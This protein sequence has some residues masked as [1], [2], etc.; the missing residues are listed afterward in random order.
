MKTDNFIKPF[1]KFVLERDTNMYKSRHPGHRDG[2]SVANLIEEV[3]KQFDLVMNTF[4]EA[5]RSGDPLRYNM[6]VNQG[7][8]GFNKARHRCTVVRTALRS[9]DRNGVEKIEESVKREL[10]GFSTIA[11]NKLKEKKQKEMT[12]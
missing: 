2:I 8:C 3:E 10:R 1:I 5:K 6:E 7:N 12:R 11:L 9:I 4:N